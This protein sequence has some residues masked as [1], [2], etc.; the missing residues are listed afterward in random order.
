VSLEFVAFDVETANYNRGSICAVGWAVVHRGEIANIG[1]SLCRPPD[2]VPWLD[3][4]ISRILGITERGVA[5]QP[6][7]ECDVSGH[8]S[9]CAAS[10]TSAATSG[11]VHR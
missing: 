11:L 1:S 5:D 7:F 3:P 9:C 10:I 4:F 2:A 8:S 6:R